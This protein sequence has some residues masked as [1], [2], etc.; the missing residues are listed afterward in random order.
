MEQQEPAVCEIEG[1]ARQTGVAG[2]GLEEG[3]VADVARAEISLASSTCS[4][5]KSTP[6][7]E[8]EGPT[9]SASMRVVMPTPQPK[10]ATFIPALR[11]ASANTPRANGE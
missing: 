3:Y 1:S 6:V 9:I 4:A 11:P 5:L 7:T 2:I 8:P 10:S